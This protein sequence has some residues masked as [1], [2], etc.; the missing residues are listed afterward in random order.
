MLSIDLTHPAPETATT[1]LSVFHS[2]AA[3]SPRTLSAG[4]QHVTGSLFRLQYSNFNA[5]G[6]RSCHFSAKFSKGRP[7]VSCVFT[8]HF[9]PPAPDNTTAFTGD[10]C[11]CLTHLH[12]RTQPTQHKHTRCSLHGATHHPVCYCR[13]TCQ[14]FLSDMAN[15]NNNEGRFNIQTSM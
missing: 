6:W 15:D 7:G 13:Y 8:P 3:P 12:P 11:L 2:V 4:L 5:R 10:T 1:C 14:G 9:P